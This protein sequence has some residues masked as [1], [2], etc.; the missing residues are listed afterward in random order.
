MSRTT[1]TLNLDGDLLKTIDKECERL[2]GK[3]AQMRSRF[4]NRILKGQLE[5]PNTFTETA[6]DEPSFF[7]IGWVPE[8]IYRKLKERHG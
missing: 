2:Y 8:S 5:N 7:I 4:V 1:V 6:G 3:D